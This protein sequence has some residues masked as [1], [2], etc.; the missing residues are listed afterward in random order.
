MS[1]GGPSVK[2]FFERVHN[3]EGECILNWPSVSIPGHLKE[4]RFLLGA[5]LLGTLFCQYRPAH[6]AEPAS[7]AEFFELRIRPVFAKNCYACHTSARMGGLELTSRQGLLQGGS[8]GPA[9][10]PGDPD[11][12]LLLK[13][14]RRTHDRLK[15]PPQGALADA[16]IRDLESWVKGGAIWPESAAGTAGP[17]KSYQISPKQRAFWAFRPV[18]KP[19]VP[20][21]KDAVW[22]KNDIDRF[23]LA[24]LEAKGLSPGKPADKRTLLRRVYYDIIGLPPT[25][26]EVDA[27]LGDNSP[28]AF[29]KIVDHLLASPHYGERWG[30]YWLDIARYGDDRLGG[31]RD[32]PHPNAWRYRDWVVSSLNDDMPFDKFVK[33]QIAGDLMEGVDRKKYVAGLGYFGLSPEF[34]DDRVDALTRGFLALTVACAQCHDHK[35]DPI[36][37]KD[38][39]SLQG[40]FTSSEMYE[41][42][43]APETEVAAYQTKKKKLDQLERD[44]KDFLKKQSFQLTEILAA[45]TSRY[46]VGTSQVLA[47]SK[48]PAAEVAREQQLDPE[49]FERWLRYLREPKEHRYLDAWDAA[50][51]SNATSA[52]LGKLAASFQDLV[53][54][55]TRE[56]KEMDEYNKTAKEGAIKVLGAQKAIL[57][58]DMYFSNPRPDLPYLPP[59]GIFYYGELYQYPGSEMQVVRFLQGE[60]KTYANWLLSEIDTVKKSLPPKYDFLNTVKDAE[61][62]A[63][64]RVNIGG[65][66]E[67]LGDEA[68]RRFLQILCNG[69]PAPFQ[70][71]SGR[72]ELAEAIASPDNPLTARVMVNRIWHY[73]FGQ[74]LVKTLSNFGFL[75]DKPSHP[76]LLDWLTAHFVEDGWSV[77]KLHR[78]ILLSAAYALAADNV[79]KNFAVDPDNRLLW[80]ANRRRLDAEVLRDSL[81]LV[82]GNLD[83]TV[84][85]PPA[86]MTPNHAAGRTGPEGDADKYSTPEEWLTGRSRRAIYGYI[87]RRRTDPTLTLF[88]FPTPA[89]I[90]EQR[91]VTSTPLQGLFL[92][93]SDFMMAQAEALAKRVA[94]AAT[95]AARISQAYRLLFGR[96]AQEEEIKLGRDFLRDKPNAWAEYTQVLLSSNEFLFVQ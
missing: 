8:S 15:M 88:D 94:G 17:S 24:K 83:L 4:R 37:T 73:H 54:D 66:P 53:L 45:Q 77:K 96:D 2:D 12:S 72:L 23:I 91:F 64:L 36:P 20:Q 76:E 32:D 25:P 28:Q 35:Y 49:T 55:V 13:A 60:W 84:G 57:W 1:L 80:R 19:P 50:I 68:P 75:G 34:Q 74:G 59:L 48:R 71:G 63:N 62:P 7:P 46:L 81:L 43:I 40:I 10:V 21:P 78:E 16:E 92:L 18:V 31:T 85:G 38:F 47:G 44:L 56:K 86:W 70:K 26:E 27:F 52:E 79:E 5:T 41:Y 87:S 14:V 58:K 69:E 3:S 22:A 9:I 82:S 90:S 95:D 30:R 33:A 6:A 67:K 39:Y 89:T 61:K 29:E 51:A 93:N 11:S 65:N 42:P